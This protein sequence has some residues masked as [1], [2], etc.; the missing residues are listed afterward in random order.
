M[1]GGLRKTNG[2]PIYREGERAERGEIMLD[3]AGSF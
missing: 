2:I 1:S 3:E